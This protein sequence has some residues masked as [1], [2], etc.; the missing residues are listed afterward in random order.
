MPSRSKKASI[1]STAD[2]LAQ[3]LAKCKKAELIA[4][5]VGLANADR[6]IRRRLEAEFTVE[7]PPQELIDATRQA[8]ADATDFD[9]RDI[10]YNFDYDDEAYS[11]IERNF[12]RLIELGYLRK[13]MELALELISQG[14]HQVEMSDEGLMTDDIEDCLRIVIDALKSCDLPAENV[15]AWCKE[16]I[17]K[18]RV[19]FICDAELAALQRQFA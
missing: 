19:G 7:T 16:M 11:A 8:I 2:P 5:I 1:S 15:V 9:E 12:G 18:D 10:N 6:G 14:S 4:V 3:A 17:R 13:A